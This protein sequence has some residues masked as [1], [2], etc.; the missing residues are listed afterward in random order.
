MPQNAAKGNL[1][2]FRPIQPGC[3]IAPHNGLRG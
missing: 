2:L 3:I 1:G